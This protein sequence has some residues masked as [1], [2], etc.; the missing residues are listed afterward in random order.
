MK[1][2]DIA[3]AVF[4]LTFVGIRLYQKYFRKSNNM[5]GNK[6]ANESDSRFSSYSKEDDYEPYAKK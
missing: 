4:V 3:I 6:K 1:T 2:L 5:S